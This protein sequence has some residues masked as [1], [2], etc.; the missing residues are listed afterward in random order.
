MSHHPSLR[1]RYAIEDTPDFEKSALALTGDCLLEVSSELLRV[2][3]QI[4]HVTKTFML[5]D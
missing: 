4:F 2:M 5:R 1:A 3:G